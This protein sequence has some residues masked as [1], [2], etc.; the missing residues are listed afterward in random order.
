MDI[1]RTVPLDVAGATL[2]DDAA[3]RSRSSEQNIMKT[4]ARFRTSPLDWF[5]E[6]AV[7]ARGDGWRAYDN[8]KVVGQPVFYSGY[9]DMIKSATMRSTMLQQRLAQMTEAR[10][11]VE[12]KE[13]LLDHESKTYLLD[14]LH[15]RAEIEASLIQITNTML[16]RMVCKME[17][18][19]A[20]R[21]A[22]YVCTNLLTRAYHQGV[23]VSRAEVARLKEV[24]A[25]CAARKQSISCG[26]RRP[27][28]DLLSPR[29]YT[30]SRGSRGQPQL[31]SGWAFPPSMWCNVDS[32]KLFRCK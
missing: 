27:S 6:V 4:M 13:G 24:A 26:L 14:K 30:A 29:Y 11:Q 12:E 17:S 10:L 28:V 23:H 31:S 3:D 22:Y 2:E 5:R 7:Y 9:T 19:T 8:N 15:R 20:I 18:K 16:D 21:T 32:K 1:A 25:R